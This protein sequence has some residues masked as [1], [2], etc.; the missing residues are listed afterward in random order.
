G[1]G[2][3][4]EWERDFRGRYVTLGGIHT[5]HADDRDHPRPPS[6]NIGMYRVQL[7][8][9][10]RMAMHWHVHHDGAR[11]WRSWK[12]LGRPMPVAIALGGEAVL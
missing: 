6:H 5:I 4:P 9:P 1:L 3:G 7:L 10:R 2:S 12:A 11:H 8:G